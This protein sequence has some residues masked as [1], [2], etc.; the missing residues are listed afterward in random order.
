MKFLKKILIIPISILLLTSCNNNVGGNNNNNIEQK[1]HLQH[2]LSQKDL[3]IT[4]KFSNNPVWIKH[5][6]LSDKYL[7][8]NQELPILL[9]SGYDSRTNMSKGDSCLVNHGDPSA[10]HITNETGE[11][12]FENTT[13]SDTISSMVNAG[14]SISAGVGWFSGSAGASYARSTTS[15]R[16]SLSLIYWATRNGTV[17]FDI[18]DFGNTALTPGA[19]DLLTKGGGLDAFTTACGD[20]FVKAAQI[21][22][23]LLVNVRVEFASLSDRTEFETHLQAKAMSMASI[24]AAF[25]ASNAEIKKHAYILVTAQQF[26]GDT[27]RLAEVLGHDDGKG[28]PI[29]ECAAQNFD[30]CNEM[31]SGVIEYSKIYFANSV[32][33]KHPDNLIMFNHRIKLYKDIQVKAELPVLSKD[34]IAAKEYI[35]STIK[36]DK[37]ML[38]YLQSYRNQ[39][40]VP[41]LDP[42]DVMDLDHAILTYQDLIK[43]Y[44]KY[45]IVDSCYGDTLELEKLCISAAAQVK[46]MHESG[47]YKSYIDVAKNL[48]STL[49]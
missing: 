46:N 17:S 15:S 24:K 3:E 20:S 11:V 16:Q 29:V 40:I 42:D 4:N 13:D 35:I 7:K 8:N 45:Q 28:Y 19:Q 32:D 30:K 6:Q 12:H 21:G 44:D 9:G 48:A 37:E 47:I 22:S 43:E 49:L 26:G 5:L 2:K 31:I 1:L 23:L 14:L 34:E 27:S 10:M 36:N 33:F 18:K 41:L 25:E 39:P 38:K